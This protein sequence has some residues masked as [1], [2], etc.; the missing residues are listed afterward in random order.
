MAQP[1]ESL[2]P[3][4]RYLDTPRLHQKLSNTGHR[5]SEIAYVASLSN[6][7]GHHTKASVFDE[8]VIVTDQTFDDYTTKVS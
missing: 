6:I 1:S 7:D 2:G 4:I 5:S 8:L 3:D